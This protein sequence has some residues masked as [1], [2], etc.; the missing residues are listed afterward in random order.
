MLRRAVLAGL[1]AALLGGA[2]L[3][4]DLTG[5]LIIDSE[6]LYSESLFGQRIA[7]ELVAETETLAA[8]NRKLEADLTAE[9]K[10]LTERRPGMEVDAFRAEAEAF[11]AK[12]QAIRAARDAK[13]RALQQMPVSGREAF[14]RAARPAITALLESRDATVVLDKRAVIY[15]TSDADITDDAIA[16]VDADIGDGTAN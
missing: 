16:A 13:E 3:A 12:V 2:A 5:V 8:E 4:Q 6:R 11:D 7:A 15:A 9:A 10:S 1:G 14:F